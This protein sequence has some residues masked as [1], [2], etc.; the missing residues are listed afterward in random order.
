VGDASVT[1]SVAAQ[2]PAAPARDGTITIS[3]LNLTFTIHQLVGT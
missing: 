3:G 1:Y 2:L